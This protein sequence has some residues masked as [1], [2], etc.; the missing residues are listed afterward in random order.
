M[1][2]GPQKTLLNCDEN[3]NLCNRLDHHLKELISNDDS[4]LN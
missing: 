1:Y 2:F 4:L 3:L